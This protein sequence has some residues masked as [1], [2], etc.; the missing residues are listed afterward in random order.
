MFLV[1]GLKSEKSNYSCFMRLKKYYCKKGVGL[2]CFSVSKELASAAFC[3]REYIV[4]RVCVC[5]CV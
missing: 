4:L 3:Y 5:L 2:F 1:A